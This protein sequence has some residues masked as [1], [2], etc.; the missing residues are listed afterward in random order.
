[1]AMKWSVIADL[2]SDKVQIMCTLL[3]FIAAIPMSSLLAVKRLLNTQYHLFGSVI[4]R[5]R[6]DDKTM[7]RCTDSKEISAH[8]ALADKQTNPWKVH[9]LA[10]HNV[11]CVTIL[12]HSFS[13]VLSNETPL[14]S[15]NFVYVASL[16]W[17]A[18][19]TV[20]VQSNATLPLHDALL[21][22]LSLTVHFSTFER[23]IFFVYRST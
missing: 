22:L 17:I 15:F 23:L 16:L 19:S 12:L 11:P 14:F 20:C 9:N 1:M 5:S 3:T 4:V 18:S 6:E 2:L 7:Q 10:L 21:S 8:F 13:T